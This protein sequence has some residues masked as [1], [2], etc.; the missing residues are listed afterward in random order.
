MNRKHN[1]VRVLGAALLCAVIAAASLVGALAAQPVAVVM[2]SAADYLMSAVPNARFGSANGDW[3]IFGLSRSGISVDKKYCAEWYKSLEKALISSDGV[4]SKGK[5]TEYSRA[6]VAATAAGYNA[7]NIAGYD[8]TLPVSDFNTV[9]AQG[10]N[11]AAW[12]LLALDCGNYSVAQN[13]AV[14]VQAT[15]QKYVDYI[16]G[17]EIENGGW[18]LS[19]KRADTDVTCMVIQALAKYTKTPGVSD[20]I[21]RGLS[22]LS[23]IKN[24]NGGFS[25]FGVESAESCAQVVIAL[26][27]LGISPYDSRFCKSGNTALDALLSYQ[28]KNGSFAH[29]PGS[30]TSQAATEQA[31]LALAAVYRAENGLSTLF[32]IGAPTAAEQTTTAGSSSHY[33]PQVTQTTA[34]TSLS[35][36]TQA[37]APTSS[38]AESVTASSQ[39]SVQHERVTHAPTVSVTRDTAAVTE[40][41]LLSDTESTTAP[42]VLS[43]NANVSAVQKVE[44]PKTGNVSDHFA[45]VLVF[46]GVLAPVGF[47]AWKLRNKSKDNGA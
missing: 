45:A 6:I 22:V 11:G 47:L 5:Y 33:L 27:E 26:C 39:V 17:K 25:S 32:S 44:V 43:D 20:A 19:G 3:E 1:I 4:L 29:E 8:L 9:T 13:N 42:A 12:A 38:S 34:T 35:V 18:A 36:T 30:N 41:A 16:L 46:A 21:D 10:I 31:L 14:P 24:K 15:R 28:L 2:N 37:A 40:S 7:K 23:S